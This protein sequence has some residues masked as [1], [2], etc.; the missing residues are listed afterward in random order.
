[1]DKIY[2]FG[3][4]YLNIA[5][6]STMLIVRARDRFWKT[7]PSDFLVVTV[8]AE[9]LLVIIIGVFG[10]LELAP[11]GFLPVAVILA[12]TFLVTFLINDSVKVYLMKQFSKK[13]S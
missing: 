9:F 13:I 6:V 4:A 12:Y 5:G 10:F 1:M 7:R 8:L 3:F 11:L 2:T